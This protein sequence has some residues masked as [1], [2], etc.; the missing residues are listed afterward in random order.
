MTDT[1]PWAGS[2]AALTFASLTWVSENDGVSQ[3]TMP[4]IVIDWSR[5]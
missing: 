4:I 3:G 2:L 5:L 1:R